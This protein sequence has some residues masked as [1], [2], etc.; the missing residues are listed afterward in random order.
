MDNKG[1]K[2]NNLGE[3]QYYFNYFP[4]EG[5]RV[6]QVIMLL[7]G[8]G[9]KGKRI[10]IEGAFGTDPQRRREAWEAA[11]SV[12]DAGPDHQ[13]AG[14][15]IRVMIQSGLTEEEYRLT[16]PR[17]FEYAGYI[18][19]AGNNPDTNRFAYTWWNSAAVGRIFNVMARTADRMGLEFNDIASGKCDEKKR[20]ALFARVYGNVEQ[21]QN[22]LN[23]T[24]PKRD[25]ER[26]RLKT[27]GLTSRFLKPDQFPEV[28]P[29]QAPQQK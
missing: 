12:Q 15:L 6:C 16:C 9:A 14:R 23:N 24:D 13:V 20:I 19:Y 25:A 29:T 11:G 27:Y 26:E 2:D 5:E 17:I 7:L 10:S 22:V 21:M 18:E 28:P 1:G 3:R 8:E 4:P